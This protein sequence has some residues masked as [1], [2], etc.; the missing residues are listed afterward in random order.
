MMVAQSVLP[1]VG[2]LVHE[3]ASQM[4]PQ[5]ALQWG[6]WWAVRK[7]ALWAVQ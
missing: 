3:K 1:T 7:V 5:K 4:A 2:P 6:H